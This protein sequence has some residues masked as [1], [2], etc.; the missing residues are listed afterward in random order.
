MVHPAHRDVPF[1]LKEPTIVSIRY[2]L[3]SQRAREPD[4]HTHIHTNSYA[5]THTQRE[6]SRS[7]RCL[8][9][10]HDKRSSSVISAVLCPR[11]SPNKTLRTRLRRSCSHTSCA[12]AA[13]ARGASQTSRS[14]CRRLPCQRQHGYCQLSV[15]HGLTTLVNSTL[16]S[17]V[18]PVSQ[19]VVD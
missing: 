3:E 14:K 12:A 7:M 9:Y 6:T 19:H 2:G 10:S 4:T 8:Q 13:A 1:R 18:N 11:H 17:A 5:Y 15:P 16:P